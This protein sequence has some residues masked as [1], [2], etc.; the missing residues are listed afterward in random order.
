MGT[1]Q[2]F[3]NKIGYISLQKGGHVF[4]KSRYIGCKSGYKFYGYYFKMDQGTNG[5]W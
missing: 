4:Y 1:K 5:Q 3:C 2:Y